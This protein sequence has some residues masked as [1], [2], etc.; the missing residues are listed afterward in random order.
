MS[1]FLSE[2]YVIPLLLSYNLRANG[3]FVVLLKL[4]RI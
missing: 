3:K 1:W 2:K 4:L